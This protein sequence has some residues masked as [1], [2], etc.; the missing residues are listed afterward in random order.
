MA[1]E[2]RR[3]KTVLYNDLSSSLG[4]MAETEERLQLVGWNSRA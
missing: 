3:I 1:G 2:L 4:M